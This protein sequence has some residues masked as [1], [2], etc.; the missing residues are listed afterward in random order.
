M[1]YRPAQSYL[2]SCSAILE[3][4]RAY[5]KV[6]Q[7]WRY[8]IRIR[9]ISSGATRSL[10]TRRRP[11]AGPRFAPAVDIIDITG[12]DVP[13]RLSCLAYKILVVDERTNS[14]VCMY[15]YFVYMY[16]LLQ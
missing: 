16:R 11:T 10:P 14:I 4:P 7:E 8:T 9:G 3:E 5:P 12:D 1:K 6:P 15:V 2:K 13:D